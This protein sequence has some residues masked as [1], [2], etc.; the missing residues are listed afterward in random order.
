MDNIWFV[1]GQ[2]VGLMIGFFI[3]IAYESQRKKKQEDK[4]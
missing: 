1:I 2:V 4:K 3:G